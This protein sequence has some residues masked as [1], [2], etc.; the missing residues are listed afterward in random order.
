VVTTA[1]FIS[2]Q[3]ETSFERR[4][5]TPSVGS[6]SVDASGNCLGAVVSGNYYK[7]T[8]LKASN[9][10]DVSVDVDTAGT[11]TITTDTVNGYFFKASS[12]FNNA[13]TQVIRLVGGGTP[14]AAGTNIFTVSY[15]GTTCEFSITVT[16]AAGGSA[17]F[18]I[19]CT[20]PTFAGTY[21]AG[22]LLTSA[23][24]VTLN[25]YV[26]TIGSWSVTTAPSVNGV[27]FAG[28]GNFATTGAQTIKL[29]A[30][31]T[32]T[33]AGTNNHTVTGA[34]ATCSFPLTVNPASPPD[35]FPRTQNSNWSYE[36]DND[37]IDSILIYSQGTVTQAGNTYNIFWYN[38]GFSAVD[39]FGLYRRSGAD[40]FENSQDMSYSILDNPYRGE[41]LF[42]KDN[43][44]VNATWNSNQF[45]G[46][47][48]DP[49]S[50]VT[51]TI[52]L[53]WQFTILQQ[54][55]TVSVT[56][57]TGTVNY[58]NVIEVKQE[59]RQ[60]VGSSWELVAYFR[61]YYARDKG[62]VKQDL[63][64]ATGNVIQSSEVRRLIVY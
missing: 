13:G 10:V 54:N 50:G 57:S 42:L 53:R 26:T 37:A 38:D 15:N 43:Q 28:S 45:S 23:E 4:N 29:T 21:K 49:Q 11:Y 46:N 3:K 60:L 34:S 33:A 24:T 48:T 63:Y 1:I 30:S 47:Y 41:I 39:T 52:T 17:V 62:L 20:G 27:T 9:Y 36:Y 2:C 61:N 44:T 51:G 32:P 59:M 7:D 12:T 31:G 25:V 14:L 56:T 18:S 35:Y 5:G 64:D 8:L 6:L 19:T 16:A 58:T 55:G 22:S 40:Y